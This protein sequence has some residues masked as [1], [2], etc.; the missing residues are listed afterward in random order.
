MIENGAT[1]C[2]ASFSKVG[3]S[4]NKHVLF[5]LTGR[6]ALKEIEMYPI[7]L[8]HKKYILRIRFC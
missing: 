2:D 7:I 1:K 6:M 5:L 4:E 8:E 3:K